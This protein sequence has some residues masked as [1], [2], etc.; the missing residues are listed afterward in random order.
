MRP[1][2]GWFVELFPEL[3]AA[4]PESNRERLRDVLLEV[5]AERGNTTVRSGAR[6]SFPVRG[7]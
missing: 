6:S 5:L 2:P 7:V 4:R 1:A 3:Y